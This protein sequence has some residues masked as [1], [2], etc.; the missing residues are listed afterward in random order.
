MRLI[1]HRGASHV[2][3]ENTLA[4]LHLALA[5]GCGFEVDLQLLRDGTLV[6]LH[7]DTLERTAA[8]DAAL[9]MKAIVRTPIEQL[10]WAEVADVD[11]GSWIDAERFGAERVPRF[12]DVLQALAG[13]GAGHAPREAPHCFAELKA[14]E[15]FD[16]ALPSAAV[17]AVDAARVP[18]SSLTWI[19]FSVPVLV[20]VKRLDAR[21]SALYVASP[22]TAEEA[23]RAARSCVRHELDGIDLRARA[24]LVTPELVDW[25]HARHKRVAVWV[26]RAPAAEDVPE[27]WA[28]MEAAGVDDFTSNLPPAIL[29]WKRAAAA[30]GNS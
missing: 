10:R 28:A 11:V 16:P 27:L 24:D 30:E 9:P 22:K 26:G 19:S 3:P 17:R 18:P 4:A 15:P 5:N 21:F 20:E 8:P 13:A 12:A 1:G 23:W 6:V 29:A 25:M 7:D 14:A 2:A